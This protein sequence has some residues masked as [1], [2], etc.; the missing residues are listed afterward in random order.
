MSED[1]KPEVR[2][3]FS[4]KLSAIVQMLQTPNGALAM[5][6]E[7]IQAVLKGTGE[8]TSQKAKYHLAKIGRALQR[9]VNEFQEAYFALIKEL[10]KEQMIDS[11]TEKEEVDGKLVPKKVPSGQ[12]S[13]SGAAHSA[14]LQKVEELLDVEVCIKLRPI[15]LDEFGPEGLSNV[16]SDSLM[17]CTDFI[18]D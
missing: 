4:M 17:A 13:V 6:N 16:S 10:G 18:V 11:P 15:K 14:F 9:E 12:Y 5:L 2:Q 7:K 3:D 8:K 1:N